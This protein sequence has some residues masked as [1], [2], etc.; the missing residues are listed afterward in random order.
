MM[1][2]SMGKVSSVGLVTNI[3][4]MNYGMKYELLHKTVAQN[5]WTKLFDSF[6]GRL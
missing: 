6:E 2:S 4:N 3:Y 1:P 5:C